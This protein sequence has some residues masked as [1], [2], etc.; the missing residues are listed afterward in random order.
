MTERGLYIQMYSIHGLIRGHD[1]EL[2]RDA[3]T[4]GQTKYVIEL[5]QALSLDPRI[6]KVEL[7]TRLIKD[8]NVSPDYSNPKEIINDKFSIIRIKCGGG[9]Y[10]RKEL[11]WLHLE[12]FIDG[13]IY[14]LSSVKKLPDLFHGH[15]A[16]AG[17]VCGELSGF[18]GIPF[19]QTGHS[20]GK[21]K[22]RK[23]LA[24]GMEMD[25][26]EK[27]FKINHRI[28]VEQEVINT[29]NFIITGTKQEIK[30]QYG[31]YE[32]TNNDKFKIIPPGVDLEKFYPYNENNINGNEAATL[33]ASITEKLLSFLIDMNKPLILSL[34]RPAKKK[35]ISGLITAYGE[36]KELQNKSNLAIFAGIRTDILT[37]EDNEREVLT[38]ILLLM[39]KYNLYG[40]MAIP[41]SHDAQLEVPEL[42]RISAETGGIFVNAALTEPFGL[43][44]I[45]SAATGVPIVATDDGGPRDIISNC[46]NGI[47]V[48]VSNPSNIAD[49]LNKIIDDKKL[50]KEF[51]ESGIKNVKKYY[52]WNAHVNKYLELVP[53]ML[54]NNSDKDNKLVEIGK[55]LL[56]APKLIITDID[57]TLIGD[58]GSLKE[59]NMFLQKNRN[60]IGFAVATGRN[61]KSALSVLNDNNV[62]SPELIISSVGSEIY[63]NQNNKLVYSKGWDSYI[64]YLWKRD[65]IIKV[66]SQ[67]DFLKPQEDDKQEKFKISY[68]MNDSDGNLE[69]IKEALAKNKLKTNIIYSQGCFL[70]VLPHRA[71]KGNAIR[72]LAFKW[73]ISFEDI[74]V[75]GDSGNDTEMLKVALCGVVVANYSP[76]MEILKE[77]KRIYFANNSFAGGILEGI[78]HYNFLEDGLNENFE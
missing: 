78:R 17:Y 40:K 38:E 46:K 13:S 42:Y 51:S 5:G 2:G 25:D 21:A 47:L 49:A 45:E 77:N 58:E 41:K 64:S 33:K 31:E 3:D 22:L 57:H 1:L 67:F 73:N 61:A 30:E 27:K 8:K 6:E 28:K 70:D 68:Y 29:A 23:L 36:S 43:T 35:N 20:L 62:I 71:S 60:K 72:Y 56:K 44:V 32:I 54:K 50:W 9:R 53:N 11:L 48:D 24:D 34:C 4:G 75:A 26:V 37:M 52:T 55:K 65:K 76:E 74:M 12:E 19:I 69:K 39:D 59:F 10:I 16:D 18:F 14:Y 66:L 15:Y 63:Y 7:V